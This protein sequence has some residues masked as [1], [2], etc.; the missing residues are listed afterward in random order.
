M[1]W[2]QILFS[3]VSSI[4]IIRD[5]LSK[6]EVRKLYNSV[7]ENEKKI[8]IAFESRIKH[9]LERVYFEINSLKIIMR[10]LIVAL[11]LIVILFV[12]VSILFFIMLSTK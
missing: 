12:I 11:V 6:E 10:F 2:I 7:K 4:N 1:K 3:T 9:E 5:F 8:L